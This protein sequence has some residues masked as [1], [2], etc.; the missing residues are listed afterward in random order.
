[1]YG[2]D[3]CI[4]HEVLG[5][6]YTRGHDEAGVRVDQLNQYVAK[7]TKAGYTVGIISQLEDT[8]GKERRLL[9]DPKSPPHILREITA[10][11]TPGT[12][13]DG[14][15]KY[16]FAAFEVDSLFSCTIYNNQTKQ[17]SSK[18]FDREQLCQAVIQYHP[19]EVVWKGTDDSWQ[20]IFERYAS[21][22]YRIDWIAHS[23]ADHV[24]GEDLEWVSMSMFKKYMG[25][26][27]KPWK[28]TTPRSVQPTMHMDSRTLFNVY[29]MDGTH[30][31]YT[32]LAPH[33]LTEI[34]KDRLRHRLRH[35]YSTLEDIEKSQREIKHWSRIDCARERAKLGA[36]KDKHAMKYLSELQR[37]I[38]FTTNVEK[39]CEKLVYLHNIM[40]TLDINIHVPPKSATPNDER[41]QQ[42]TKQ[43]FR[44]SI[45]Q[46]EKHWKC[47]IDD[48]RMN[49]HLIEI[50][51]KHF[52]H[53]DTIITPPGYI[54][55]S[56]T[57]K[58]MRLSSNKAMV[59]ALEAQE[60]EMNKRQSVIDGL[61]DAIQKIPKEACIDALHTLGDRDVETTIAWLAM[62]QKWC[63]PVFGSTY[64]LESA[65]LPDG[66]YPGVH[67]PTN[68]D[69][70]GDTM[71]LTG[72]N[73]SGKSTL[74]KKLA[75][76]QI[77][78]QCGFY[79]PA[80][81]A[82]LPVMTS[83]FLRFGSRDALLQGESSFATEAKHMK[84]ICDHVNHN[85]LVLVDEFGSSTTAKE[86]AALAYGAIQWLCKHATYVLFAT[87]YFDVVRASTTG[88]RH[89]QM[90]FPYT[91]TLQPGCAESS[92]A[93]EILK[94][95]TILGLHINHKK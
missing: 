32:T 23:M 30:S 82:T 50:P 83:L 71:L 40:K 67:I 77:M 74:M 33:C 5:L 49:K 62:E 65:S 92:H 60:M 34:G 41:L 90:P 3:A 57:K 13:D 88:T 46:F 79:I 25:S 69:L 53:R 85:A 35:P 95:Y 1:M 2:N 68:M 22:I 17:C 26:L 39:V 6:K 16:I 7:I 27:K 81:R 36:L 87:H 37:P 51:M 15:E 43:Y 4:C 63:C 11:E 24:R 70:V 76:I 44:T 72:A 91:Y 86:G 75:M 54:R 47:Y 42:K 48:G 93:K 19:L 59:L 8:K 56:Q 58:Y 64:S 89:V 18:M 10:I 21:G 73:G 45:K 38:G 28:P 29:D 55:V 14:S 78:A 84:Y 20:Q 12:F 61:I 66:L 31:L 52:K 9:K 94:K 80:T